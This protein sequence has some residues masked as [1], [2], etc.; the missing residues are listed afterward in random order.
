MSHLKTPSL[1]SVKLIT[2]AA[3][4]LVSVAVTVM[5]L[6]EFNVYPHEASGTIAPAKRVVSNQIEAGDVLGEGA[7]RSDTDASMVGSENNGI[8][9]SAGSSVESSLE[10]SMES[11]LSSSMDR[12]TDGPPIY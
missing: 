2:I 5:A 7:T 8:G 3:L 10:S 4:A 6:R 9:G 12:S 1:R 11:S